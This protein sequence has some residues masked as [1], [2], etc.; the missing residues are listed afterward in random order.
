MLWYHRQISRYTHIGLLPKTVAD[1][2]SVTVFKTRHRRNFSGVRAV[3][4][5]ILS[6][7]GGPGHRTPSPILSATKVAICSH[8]VT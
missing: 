5:P 3:R 7:V 1:S 6:K 2:D 4:V 8:S